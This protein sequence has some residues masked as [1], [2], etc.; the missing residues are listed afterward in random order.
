MRILLLL[1]TLNAIAAFN[2]I[3]TGPLSVYGIPQT[4]KGSLITSSGTQM[5]ESVVCGNG[6][7]LEWDSS[8]TDGVACT[9]RASDASSQT[10]SSFTINNTDPQEGVNQTLA[11]LSVTTTRANQPVLISP[12]GFVTDINGNYNQIT[13]TANGFCSVRV[14]LYRDGAIVQKMTQVRNGSTFGGDYSD[15]DYPMP[16]AVDAPPTAGTYSYTV[17]AL[18]SLGGGGTACGWF[19]GAYKAIL[20]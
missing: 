7:I 5:G 13:V 18:V 6:Q 8:Q 12:T 14:A 16:T 3:P 4:T 15:L 9:N 10:Y 11:T 19:A 1:F 17:Q 20:L 2:P